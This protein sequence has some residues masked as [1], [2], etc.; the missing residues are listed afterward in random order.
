MKPTRTIWPWWR[1]Q[2]QDET[3]TLRAGALV[4]VIGDGAVTC[5]WGH[6]EFT[7]LWSVIHGL[8]GR[9][10]A[11]WYE[12]TPVP[13]VVE[14]VKLGDR[15]ILRVVSMVITRGASGLP[16]QEVVT[17]SRDRGRSWTFYRVHTADE[18]G[19]HYDQR[20]TRREKIPT[21]A[22]A[23]DFAAGWL[24]P[25]WNDSSWPAWKELEPAEIIAAASAAGREQP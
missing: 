1:Y 12:L 19:G 6:D 20:S 22:R 9:H 25:A 21:Q 4:R 18:A 23:I 14:T 15:R 8:R 13:L 7:G 10:A 17:L 3:A 2:P 5:P 24:W 16:G 11:W